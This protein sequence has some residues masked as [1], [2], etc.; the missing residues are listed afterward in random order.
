MEYCR[1]SGGA[2]ESVSVTYHSSPGEKAVYTDGLHKLSY[3]V[4]VHSLHSAT[5]C[6]EA[7]GRLILLVDRVVFL[8]H[9]FSLPPDFP[10]F[11]HMR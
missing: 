8:E 3:F 9:E 7:R 4:F 1:A 11:L 5:L 10:Q 2:R 6:I